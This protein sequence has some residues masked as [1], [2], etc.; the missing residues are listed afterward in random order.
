[1]ESGPVNGP[2]PSET[3][4][5][6][7]QGRRTTVHHPSTELV[8]AAW[9]ATLPG[10]TS[11]MVASTLPKDH[12]TWEATGLSEVPNDSCLFPIILPTTTSS[13]TLRGG[14]KIIHG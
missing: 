12:A 7:D 2:P 8:A 5:V 11:S 10:I 6:K 9:L 13:G 3:R 4:A 1:M 14:G